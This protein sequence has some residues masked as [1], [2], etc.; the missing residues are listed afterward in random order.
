MAGH[1]RKYARCDGCWSA[2]GC[3][4]A[5]RAFGGVCLCSR[6]SAQTFTG[7]IAIHFFYLNVGRELAPS[8]VRVEIPRWVAEDEALTGMLHAVLLAISATSWAAR[9]YPYALHRSHEVA[10][11][12][13]EEKEQL[14]TMI[15]RGTP[16][17]AMW[18]LMTLRNKQIC[19]RYFRQPDRGIHEPTNCNWTIVARQH[20]GLCGGLPAFAVGC[21]LLWG[22]AAHPAGWGGGLP[23]L[24]D[25]I[26]DIHVDDDG[27]VRQLATTEQVSEDVILDNR[28]NR[29]VPLEISVVFTGHEENGEVR[30]LTPPRPPLSL[31]AIYTCTD[32]ELCRFTAS[33][34]FG[35]FRH[36][37]R[38]ADLPVGELLAAHSAPG[39]RGPRRH[40]AQP[41]SDARLGW[42][43]PRRS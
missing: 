16:Q 1:A 11:V 9:P 38:N 34:R 19:E 39:S 29:N 41:C 21:A 15:D 12:R 4:A 37:L 13:F 35:Y 33:G 27:L 14:K 40:Q 8:L 23:D 32:E 18:Q 28:V 3:A 22:F 26:Y 24:S 36:V 17:A 2:A 6:A 25:L 43:A 5:W 10:V 20:G 31:D 7:E 30:H 42:S